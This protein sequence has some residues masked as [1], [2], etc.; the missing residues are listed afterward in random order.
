MY[1]NGIALD[2]PYLF[3][4]PTA[5]AADDRTPAARSMAGPRGR[6]VRHGRPPRQLGRLP[7]PSGP[8]EISHVI[9]RAW[10]RYWPFDTFGILQTPTYPSLQPASP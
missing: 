4:E 3:E 9:G 8:I 2:E 6:A 5:S 1:V 7:R 10:L